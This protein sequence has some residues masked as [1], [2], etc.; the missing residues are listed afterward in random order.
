MRVLAALA[1]VMLLAGCDDQAGKAGNATGSFASADGAEAFVKTGSGFDYRYAFRVPGDRV[2]AV[3]QSNAAGCDA[4][5][6]A[7]CRIT[8][9]RY[10]VDNSNHIRAVLTL[11]IDPAI[12]RA[13]GEAAVKTL[14]SADGVLVDSEISGADVTTTARTLAII[15]RLR[16]RLKSAQNAAA[17][18]PAAKV[19]AERIKSALDTIAESEAGQGQT[20]ATAPVLITYE[21]SNALTG[22]GSADANFRNAGKSFETTISRVLIVLAAVGPWF[23]LLIGLILILRLVVHGTGGSRAAEP[24]VSEEGYAAERDTGRQ[25]NRNLIQRWFNRDDDREP[26]APHG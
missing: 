20:L 15:G 11:N 16:D 19:Q 18:D 3:L 12:A 17:T 1:A 26:E 9:M 23:L 4:I 14:Q 2:K 24:E 10:S 5:G 6:P 25:D 7:Q 8:G 22:L 13:F 21:S